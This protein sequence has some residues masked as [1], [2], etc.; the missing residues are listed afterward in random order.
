M[1]AGGPGCSPGAQRTVVFH[2]AF[3][4][5]IQSWYDLLCT[6]AR[7]H[8]HRQ[9]ALHQC[10]LVTQAAQQATKTCPEGRAGGREGVGGG[11]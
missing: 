4:R 11:A 8:T 2:A 6:H 1:D 10:M 3:T 9:P 7:T 5:S